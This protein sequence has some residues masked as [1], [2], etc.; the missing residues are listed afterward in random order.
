MGSDY[1]SVRFDAVAG[2]T[3]YLV[4]DGDDAAGFNYQ[5]S[6][7]CPALSAEGDCSDGVD[8]DGD[9]FIDCRDPDCVSAEGCVNN[10]CSFSDVVGCGSVL[11]GTTTGG[12]SKMSQY[13]CMPGLSLGGPERVYQ[14]SYDTGPDEREVLLSLFDETSY[15][16]VSAIEESPLL[17]MTVP[18]QNFY[19][20]KDF[21]PGF[22]TIQNIMG[23][24]P[25]PVPGDDNFPMY[26][27]L[28]PAYQI[29]DGCCPAAT[30]NDHGNVDVLFERMG[31]IDGIN[32][33][34]VPALAPG[35]SF[36]VDV[37]VSVLASWQYSNPDYNY[38]FYY[39]PLDNFSYDDN[40]VRGGYVFWGDSPNLST[41]FYSYLY[42][43]DSTVSQYAD[44]TTAQTDCTLPAGAGCNVAY[45]GLSQSPTQQIEVTGESA[46]CHP[47]SCTSGNFYA[48]SFTA[49]KGVNYY[50]SV[51]GYYDAEVDFG[52]AVIC[53]PTSTETSCSDG[54]DEDGDFL[55]DC[56]DPDCEASCSTGATCEPQET[57]DCGTLRLSGTTSGAGA[58]DV[59]DDYLCNDFSAPG[60]EYAY[61]FTATSTGYTWFTT[62][63]ITSYVV[64]SVIEDVA[65]SCDPYDCLDTNYYGAMAYVEEGK[66]YHVVVD[67]LYEGETADY[68]LSV[69]CNPT[70]PETDCTNGVD[71]DADFLTDS[72]DPD[73]QQ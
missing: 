65:G 4:V 53:D 52:L 68:E 27:Y 24:G 3:Y 31:L 19:S 11:A 29:D 23:A 35:E 22:V 46:D 50:I 20:D 8:G 59:I 13:A 38:L 5:A 16:T 73:C 36:D 47:L 34:K 64:V 2:E 7:V 49:R 51:E 63:N 30:C 69:V 72:E 45:Y 42:D 71:D 61:T 54:V 25:T 40:F 41:I 12:E 26:A 39:A 70:V 10:T 6:V 28:E 55:I 62:S 32:A 15:A 57:V 43:I 60:P 44:D 37:D 48:T 9:G 33:W 17:S 1:Y 21:A 56:D 67:T 14:F 58:T 18:V 66:T